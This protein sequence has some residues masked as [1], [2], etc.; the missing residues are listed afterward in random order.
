MKRLSLTVPAILAILMCAR[1][2]LAQK[3]VHQFEFKQFPAEVYQGKHHVPHYLRKDP[4]GGWIE[5]DTGK[6]AAAPAVTFAGEYDLAAYTCGTCCRFYKMTSMR[7]GREVNK[8]SMFDT[9][10]ISD[11]GEEIDAQT[12]DGHPYVPVLH[13]KPNSNLLI[14]QYQLDLCTIGAK[15]TCRQRYYVF[16]KGEFRSISKTLPFC[17]KE[18]EEPE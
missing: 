13:F 3:P 15:S 11:A 18:G 12:R 8:V 9:E 4:D 10:R 14:V 16:E 5:A 7:T 17:T 2:C 6:P 1:V